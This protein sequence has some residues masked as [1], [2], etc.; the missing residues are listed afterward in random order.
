[1]SLVA[2]RRIL[3]HGLDVLIVDAGILST[4]LRSLKELDWI[5]GELL[6]PGGVSAPKELGIE[7]FLEEINSVRD[8]GYEMMYYRERIEIK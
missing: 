3:H 1:M 8:K 4:S 5:V 2:Q 7:R 6:Q